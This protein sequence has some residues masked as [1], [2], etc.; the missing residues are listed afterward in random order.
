MKTE[1]SEEILEEEML[2]PW[3]MLPGNFEL[4]F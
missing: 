3:G 4:I 2:K 1:I